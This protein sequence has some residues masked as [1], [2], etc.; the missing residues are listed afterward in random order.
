MDNVR[1]EFYK[2]VNDCISRPGIQGLMKWCEDTGFFTQP[3]S[4][5]YHL[6]HEGGLAEHSI[7][8]YNRLKELVCLIGAE[9]KYAPETIAICA[10]FHDICKSNLYY[11]AQRWT[12]DE[13]G[14]WVQVDTYAYNEFDLP[15]H[16]EK[17]VFIVCHYMALTNEEMMAIRWHMSTWEEGKTKDVGN[18]YKLFPLALL[19]HMADE[20]ATFIDEKE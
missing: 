9:H 13:A 2:I 12:K 4:T 3:C 16:G 7:N 10:L 15:G 1:E 19:L 11:K 18:A 6:C 14:H 5:K 20:L 8:V 17:S